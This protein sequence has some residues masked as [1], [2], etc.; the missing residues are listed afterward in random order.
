MALS[1]DDTRRAYAEEIR[2]VSDIRCEPLIEALARVPREDFLGPG[3]WLVLRQPLSPSLLR[4]PSPLS[5]YRLTRDA[6]PRQL[7]HNILIA[8]DPERKLNN[9]QPSANLFWIDS[10]DLRVGDRVVHVG[11]GVGYYTAIMAEAVGPTGSVLAIECDEGLAARSRAN[12]RAWPHVNVVTGDGATFDLGEFDVGYINAGATRLMPRWL[13]GLRPGGRLLV[14]LTVDAPIS[15]GGYT[16]LVTRT[17]EC[18]SARFTG[19]VSIYP[20]DGARDRTSADALRELY[21]Q[22][23]VGDVQSLRRDPHEREATC[24]MHLDDYCLSTLPPDSLDVPR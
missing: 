11:C 12:L 20:C 9:G 22:P 5:I 18:W 16:L 6:D 24:A 8:I 17:G 15:A 19:W 3:P 7:Y 4:D 10:L 21:K 2:A 23:I 14:P 1:Q 13:A